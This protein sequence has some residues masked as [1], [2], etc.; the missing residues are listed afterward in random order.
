MTDQDLVPFSMRLEESLIESLKKEARQIS[1]NINKD[2]TYVDLIREV[3]G[4]YVSKIKEKNYDKI[5]TIEM[6]DST[7]L[8]DFIIPE[9]FPNMSQSEWM[10]MFGLITNTVG[11]DFV[12]T[13]VDKELEKRS[14]ARVCLDVHNLGQPTHYKRPYNSIIQ[15]L[16][17]RGAVPD[18]IHEGEDYILPTFEIACNPTLTI[19]EILSKD[20][21][22]LGRIATV[23]FTAI[24]KEEAANFMTLLAY[25]S[26]LQNNRLEFN[27][28]SISRLFQGYQ[29]H[30]RETGEVPHSIIMPPDI[31]LT[32]VDESGKHKGN[33]E[34]KNISDNNAE[35]VGHFHGAPIRVTDRGRHNDVYFLGNPKKLG[36][37]QNRYNS[38]VLLAPEPLKLRGGFVVWI[39]LGM[40]TLSN[41]VT[42]ISFFAK[43][44]SDE[45]DTIIM[46]RQKN[47]NGKRKG[48]RTNP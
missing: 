33:W 34:F 7:E 19:D 18:Q 22:G 11:G 10:S 37:F 29:N 21:G 5:E 24:S 25:S 36:I 23:A 31:F 16:S 43:T 14:I 26:D 1:F 12:K 42:K 20:L 40:S 17:R 41:E 9:K 45:K 32:L 6:K 47:A 3:V 13:T 28:I 44:L 2:V 38:Q 15:V 48:R 46:G 4:N 35:V 30:L 8:S 27:N 39:G